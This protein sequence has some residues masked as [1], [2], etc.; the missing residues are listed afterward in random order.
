MP[1]DDPARKRIL[2][3]PPGSKTVPGT[4]FAMIEQAILPDKLRES[5]ARCQIHQIVAARTYVNFYD[6][7]IDHSEV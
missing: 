5:L 1:K 7:H 3:Q 6:A 2:E 4:R